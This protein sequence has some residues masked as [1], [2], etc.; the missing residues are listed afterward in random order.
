[1]QQARV[2]RH[3]QDGKHNMT[4]SGRRTQCMWPDSAVASVSACKQPQ[5]LGTQLKL[6]IHSRMDTQLK[7]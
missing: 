4:P 3:D 5:V 7:G 2:V 6:A 1:M